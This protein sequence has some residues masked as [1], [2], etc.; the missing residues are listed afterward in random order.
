MEKNNGIYIK[1]SI[2]DD[3]IVYILLRLPRRSIARFKSISKRWHRLISDPSFVSRYETRNIS[4]LGFFYNYLKHL[5]FAPVDSSDQSQDHHLNTISFELFSRIPVFILNSS[6]GLFLYLS[7][8]C[9]GYRE[10][11]YY[12]VRN[13]I[14][15]EEINFP[16]DPLREP[17]LFYRFF[18][19]GFAFDHSSNPP[20][21]IIIELFDGNNA[22]QINT[23][24]SYT[25]KWRIR[26]Q[27]FL[28]ENFTL[29]GTSTFL[30]GALHWLSP[31][32]GIL[33]YDIKSGH[34]SVITTPDDFSYFWRKEELEGV[35]YRF[36]YRYLGESRERLIYVRI[37]AKAEFF[38]WTLEDYYQRKLYL[39]YRVVVDIDVLPRCLLSCPVV[40][41][42]RRDPHVVYFNSGKR[43]FPYDLKNRELKPLHDTILDYPATTRFHGLVCPYELPRSPPSIPP[44]CYFDA[45]FG[46]PAVA[47]ANF[48]RFQFLLP[49][50]LFMR[51]PKKRIVLCKFNRPKDIVEA[52]VSSIGVEVNRVY[53]TIQKIK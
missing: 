53:S 34:I 29:S 7:W 11:S 45:I 15:E 31:P 26:E 16:T 9:S 20:H 6:N 37:S 47:T 22:L 24:S 19:N 44:E 25:S 5:S 35:R 12:V 3:V 36:P 42:D 48:K 1:D 10:Y 18:V 49:E 14:T 46:S 32:L 39:S 13:P 17:L 27:A 51:D 23:F 4:L 21:L 50:N 38:L 40:G 8:Y 52:S 2:P 43:I 41:F 33:V 30:N 28:C